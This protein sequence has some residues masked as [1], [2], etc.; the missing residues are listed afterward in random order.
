MTGGWTKGA[1]SISGVR[2]K[3]SGGEWQNVSCYDAAAKREV[4]VAAVSIDPQTLEGLAD[5]HLFADALNVANETGLTPRQLA[6][7]NK[8]L[9]A[10]LCSAER[11]V[12]RAANTAKTVSLTRDLD[13]EADGIQ[14]A[15]RNATTQKGAA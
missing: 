11:I 7:Q 9:L 13:R 15:I 2:Y 1:C 12:R 10:A 3:M 8:E 14:S 5:A 4:N 6:D